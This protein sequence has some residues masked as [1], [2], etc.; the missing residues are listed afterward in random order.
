M[1]A[2]PTGIEVAGSLAE[3]K[4]HVLPNDYPDLDIRRMQINI[5]EANDRILA[6]MSEEA[7]KSAEKYLR[8][9]DIYFWLNP[10]VKSFDGQ[11]VGFFSLH[12][13]FHWMR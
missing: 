6:N 9:K 13:A 3:L 8:K 11:N 10:R 7:S 1:G 4:S 5:I 2:G 12:G